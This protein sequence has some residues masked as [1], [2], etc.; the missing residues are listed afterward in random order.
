M[1][2]LIPIYIAIL[3]TV[4]ITLV[5]IMQKRNNAESARDKR[6]S[7]V[8]IPW[9]YPFDSNGLVSNNPLEYPLPLANELI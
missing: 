1:K 6:H 7:Y 9:N 8:Y 3:T 5:I 4:T 2:Q